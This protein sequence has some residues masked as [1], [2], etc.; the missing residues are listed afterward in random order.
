MRRACSSRAIRGLR[1]A[2]LKI[3]GLPEGSIITEADGVQAAHM[4]FAPGVARLLRT[5]PS[6]AE[7]IREIDPQF[8][9]K[10]LPALAA[11]ALKSVPA[12]SATEMAKASSADFGKAA[13][14]AKDPAKLATLVAAAS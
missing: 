2:L 1:G 11:N 12:F 7:R 13:D 5:H 4:F 6:I 10:Q 14:L 3:A 9:A 8:N